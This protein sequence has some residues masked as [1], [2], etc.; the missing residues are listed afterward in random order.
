MPPL[1]LVAQANI[2]G[3]AWRLQKK[4]ITMYSYGVR[5]C[6]QFAQFAIAKRAAV[7][8]KGARLNCFNCNGIYL[9]LHGLMYRSVDAL[10]ISIPRGDDTHAFRSAE[11]VG[12]STVQCYRVRQCAWLLVSS[13]AIPSW[14]HCNSGLQSLLIIG[15]ISYV[16]RPKACPDA[17]AVGS[18]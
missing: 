9:L 18:I 15:E 17:R 10:D 5:I 4:T 1:L 7:P 8:E 12:F 2:C 6:Q 3:A 13:K 16:L 11:V 14:T